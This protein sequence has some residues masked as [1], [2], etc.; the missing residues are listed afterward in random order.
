MLI[1]GLAR[2]SHRHHLPARMECRV[3]HVV[4]RFWIGGAERQFVARL[5]LHPS[6]F[7]AVVGCLE[8]SGP[9]LDQVRALGY[10]PVLFPMR[11]SM[12][13]ANSLKQVARMAAVIRENGVR[14]V[15]G[16][17]FHT[18]LLALAAGRLAGAR[19][20]VSRVDLGHLRDGFG[21]WH[22]EAEKWNARHADVVIANAEA[23]REVC[24]R[25]ERCKP[26]RVVVVRNGID[27]AHFDEL[28]AGP[29]QAPLP[30]APDDVA[31]AVIGNLW[32][33]KGHR[34]LVEAAVLL[35]DRMPRV[36][37]LCAGEGPERRA[38]EERI[39]ELK[40]GDRVFLLGHRLDVPA[41]L[42]RVHAACLC[43][44]AEGLSN[45]LMEAMAARLPIVAT[46]VGGNP[47]LVRPGE[48]GL[49]VPYGDAPSLADK[50][51]ELLA[52]PAR[53]AE[54]GR[55]GRSRV[56]A[57]LTLARMAEAYGAVYR[58]LLHDAPLPSPALSAQMP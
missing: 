28:C 57:E 45:A 14:I 24:I 38:L 36:K 50:L 32:P 7:E 52:D 1:E 27:L 43:S 8:L 2:R 13:R 39:A 23:V 48:N 53:A 31:V 56:E 17:D 41:I 30:I 54:M 42:A 5:Q 46:A 37:F 34:T 33:V 15:H 29:L 25:E 10:E 9:M 16:T 22:R 44:S 55:R 11:G 49:L 19:V 47:E 6:G 4:Q 12:M 3:L 21:K 20:V 40:L 58:R 26:E 18:N 35:A 51:H